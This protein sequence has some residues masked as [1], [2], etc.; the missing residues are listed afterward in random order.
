MGNSRVQ[1]APRE[2]KL[3]LSEPFTLY[4]CCVIKG[5][6]GSNLSK[7]DLD[8]KDVVALV[9]NRDTVWLLLTLTGKLTAYLLSLSFISIILWFCASH[10][11]SEAQ[12]KM[13]S[14]LSMLVLFGVSLGVV[15][16][17]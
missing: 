7:H 15:D 8:M 1:V 2:P 3:F 11:E 17:C 5:G 14:E 16:V 13:W 10:L 4:V 12:S 6:L 9:S